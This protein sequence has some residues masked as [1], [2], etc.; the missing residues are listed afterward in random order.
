MAD[1]KFHF[2]NGKILM[3]ETFQIFS[4]KKKGKKEMWNFVA[5]AQS[6]EAGA[7]GITNGMES[8]S[9]QAANSVSNISC[10]DRM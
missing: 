6:E 3:K 7:N 10:D 1:G 9:K 8:S 2:S 4:G 5:V